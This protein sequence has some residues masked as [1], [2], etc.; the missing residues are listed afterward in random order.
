MTLPLCPAIDICSSYCLLL[1]DDDD[2]DIFFFFAALFNFVFTLHYYLTHSSLNLM[3]TVHKK[4]RFNTP[5]KD[6]LTT[7]PQISN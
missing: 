2:D 6:L 7:G 1:N 4:R 5:V 3:K